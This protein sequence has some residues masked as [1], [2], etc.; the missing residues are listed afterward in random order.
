ML[1]YVYI[2]SSIHLNDIDIKYDVDNKESL[3]Y[4][5]ILYISL[6]GFPGIGKNDL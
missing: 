1:G 5:Y 4:Y 2:Y 3:I 6:S